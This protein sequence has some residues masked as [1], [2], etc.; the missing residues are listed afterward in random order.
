VIESPALW[1][2]STF[3]PWLRSFDALW[4]GAV[5]ARV[6]GILRIALSSA[7]LWNLAV[8]WPERY[9]LF[10][11]DGSL[12]PLASLRDT[13]QPGFH[14]LFHMLHGH[15]AV[16][17]VFG[18]AALSLL[19]LLLGLAPRVSTVVAWLFHLNYTRWA[20]YDLGGWDNLLRSSFFL[21]AIAPAGDPYCIEYR[22]RKRPAPTEH[23]RYGLVLLRW[24]VLIVYVSTV[25]LKTG[26]VHWRKGDVLSYFHTSVFSRVDFEWAFQ[27]PALLAFA[28]YATMVVELGLPFLLWSKRLRPLGFALGIGLH[29]WV[30]FTTHVTIFSVVTLATYAAFL[31]GDDVEWLRR[32]LNG[33]RRR[34]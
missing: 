9:R 32:F 16:D 3:A 11:S 34:A 17:L 10:A 13:S 21:L 30:A 12:S 1:A 14:S 6:Y 8:L 18:A 19:A 7:A 28:A 20:F 24:Q 22:W 5:D 31:D 2:R 26:N 33:L 23:P 4:F 15:G 27:F 25:W 29:G